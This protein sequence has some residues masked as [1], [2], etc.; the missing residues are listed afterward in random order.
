MQIKSISMEFDGSISSRA[1]LKFDVD[2]W[3]KRWAD[4][5][6]GWYRNHV[7]YHL[8]EE[9]LKLEKA[10]KKFLRVFIPLCGNQYD[11]LWLAK[12]GHEVV[13][14]E[15]SKIAIEG[16]FKDHNLT[17]ARCK[18]KAVENSVTYKSDSMNLKIIRGDFFD[19]DP[20][21][22]LNDSKQFDLIFD[23][24]AMVCIEEKKLEKYCSKLQSLLTKGGY[25]LLEG[26]ERVGGSLPGPPY[27]LLEPKIEKLFKGYDA[28]RLI[29]SDE[30]QEVIPSE[31]G[32]IRVDVYRVSPVAERLKFD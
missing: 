27:T 1:E 15:C 32:S 19:L 8:E 24:A 16:F 7:N 26:I 9:I 31:V 12:R 13:G 18:T 29:A 21:F 14:I 25:L 17:Y 28:V 30:D 23:R 10:G 20:S 11:M 22:R 6:I 2:Y 3:N 5:S 4:N